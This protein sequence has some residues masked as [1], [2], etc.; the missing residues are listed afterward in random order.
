MIKHIKIKKLNKIDP[1][2][3]KKKIIGIKYKRTKNSFYKFIFN[4]IFPKFL[5]TFLNLLIIFE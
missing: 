5:F 4:H 1:S 2:I 3:I